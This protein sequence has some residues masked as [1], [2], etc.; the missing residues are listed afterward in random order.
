MSK[1]IEMLIKLP[2]GELKPA[3]ELK[4]EGTLKEVRR[5]ARNLAQVHIDDMGYKWKGFTIKVRNAYSRYYIT[6]HI[7]LF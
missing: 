6:K 3:Y 5:Q 4:V 1:K 2:S 7:E